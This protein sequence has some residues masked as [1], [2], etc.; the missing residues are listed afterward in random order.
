MSEIIPG[1]DGARR[2]QVAAD[3]W[4]AWRAERRGAAV[5]T[6]FSGVGKSDLVVRPL[7][8]RARDEGLAAVI[9]QA[10]LHPADLGQEMLGLLAEEIEF[11]G[12]P[13][14]AETVRGLPSFFSALALLLQRGALVVIDEFQRVLDPSTARPPEPLGDKLQRLARGVHDGCLWLVSNRQLDPVWT[15]HFHTAQLQPPDEP[16]DAQRIV[17]ENIG[18][19]AA[20]ERFP[21][22]RRAE[23]IRRLGANPR[24]LRLL[25]RL[26]QSYEL[27]ELLGPPGDVP[28]TPPDPSLTEKIEEALLSKARQGLSPEA[29]ALLRD[30]SVLRERALWPLVEAMGRHLG[31]VRALTRELRERF[32]LEVS[33]HHYQPHPVV[34][35]VEGPRLRLEPEAWR[36]A[37]RRAGD[38]YAAPL[39]GDAAALGDAALALRLSGA[40]YHLA[41]A[42][43]PEVLRDVVRSIGGYVERKYNWSGV[44]RAVSKGEL[45]AR[46]ALLSL[47]LEEPGPAAVEY[48]LAKALK[49]RAGARDLEKALTHAQRAMEGQRFS[50]PWVLWAQLVRQVHGLEAAV[51]AARKAAEHVAPDKGIYSIYQFLGAFL[52]HLGRADEAVEVLLAGA[53]NPADLNSHRLIEEATFFGAAEAS[54]DMLRRVRDW[55]ESKG[56][57]TP[58]VRLCDILLLEREGLWRQAAEAARLSRA[59]HPQYMHLALHETLCWLGAGR[60][61]SAQSALDS[62]PFKRRREPRNAGTWLAALVALHNGETASASQLLAVYLDGGAPTTAEGVRAALLREWDHRVA[63]VGEANPALT[64]PVLPPLVTG[65]EANVSRPQYGPPVLPQHRG[66]PADAPAPPRGEG[67]AAPGPE[68]GAGRP[69]VLAVATEWRSGHGGLSTLNRRLCRALAN[70]GARVVCVVL[71][72]TEAE[73]GD[74]AAGG[75]TLLE[76]ARTPGLGEFAPAQRSGLP[77]GFT[78][79]VIIG[80]GRVTGPAAQ[81]LA[82][83]HFT[84]ARRLHFVHMAPDEIEWLKPGRGD[85]AG[86]RA[87]ARTQVE[88]ELGRTAA[89]VVAVGPRL[90]QRFLNELSAYAVPAPIR[91]DPGFDSGGGPREPPPG[92]PLKV[93]MLGRLEDGPI[94]GLDLAAR[95]V[96]L[97]AARRTEAAAPVELVVRGAAP[98]TSEELRE[99]LREWAGTAALGVVVRPYTTD[100]ERLD[101][102]LRRASLVLMPSRSE[103]FG[104]VGLEAITAGT[105]AL[106][107][108]E[109]GLAELLREVL[110][111]EQAGRFV[112]QTSG[113][114]HE[115]VE[116]W[117]RAV[118]AMLRD[119]EAAFR[120]AAELR[121]HLGRQ[122]TWAAAVAGLLAELKGI[123]AGGA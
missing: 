56:Q 76:A 116:R 114:D 41:E 21:A 86:A 82:R 112:V 123:P 15:E 17:L 122:R 38:W 42:Q 106:V 85:D 69:R 27:E 99:R 44:P 47:Y 32:L 118:E 4:A 31:D 95:A 89:R 29:N 87:E 109:S 40:H 63:K 98:D 103:G 119:R 64:F 45:D 75:V 105:P 26:L 43:A 101:A 66:Q 71:E 78:P 53:E 59:D 57:F 48:Q 108:S 107:S 70:A 24:I 1:L 52:N 80:H 19:A 117:A 115:T 36:A 46:I 73:R 68:G 92:A 58:K 35:E 34:R 79:D 55:A 83:E 90:H 88:L 22:P 8:A 7:A 60:P 51:A 72:A 62:F 3:L 65:L 37:H 111:R 12:D 102:D 100:S 23:V 5:L 96:G 50:I 61:S 120:R 110:D 77:E 81:A 94:K 28:E 9:I 13:A 30:L 14:L 33:A 121:E 49:E 104:L 97:A 91:L 74:A 25:G 10:P 67:G 93:L 16:D 2:Q 113:G 18:P 6:G 39:L 11:D 20:E 54:D 84:S